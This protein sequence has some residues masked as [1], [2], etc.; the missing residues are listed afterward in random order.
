M[1]KQTNDNVY[2]KLFEMFYCE[3]FDIKNLA[4][5][6]S[7]I[8][9]NI[10]IKDIINIIIL[11]DR[12]KYYNKKSKKEMKNN[13]DLYNE[14]IKILK[15]TTTLAK[16]LKLQNS[17]EFSVLYT[18]LLWNGY[19]S[20]YKHLK[21]KSEDRKSIIGMYPLDIMSGIGV[22]I[23][24]STMLRDFLNESG[25]NCA[26]IVN[27]YNHNIHPTYLPNIERHIC[28]TKISTDILRKFS[29]IISLP[30][31]KGNHIFNLIK[32]EE[33]FYI[34]DPSNLLLL[35]V[36]SIYDC[37]LINGIGKIKLNP[38][39][40]YSFN[41]FKNE[42]KVLNSFIKS[43]SYVSP[44]NKDTYQSTTRNCIYNF[45]NNESLLSDYYDSAKE[46]IDY[47]ADKLSLI[48]TK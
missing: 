16:E 27:V 1:S 47:I 44:Y 14:Y 8:P 2:L 37:K 35:Q 17:L 9:K 26:S 42:T 30:C 28:D 3:N 23:N 31:T 12:R 11:S 34:Y 6:I 43:D 4:E 40:S 32:E 15:K 48:K 25:F 18:Y 33:K 24:F 39:Y 21:F 13:S 41:Y 7:F 5:Y 19:F 20:K 38:Y 29:K 36:E 46:N 22:C 10:N 45:K